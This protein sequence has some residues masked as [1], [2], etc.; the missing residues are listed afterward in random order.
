MVLPPQPAQSGSSSRRYERAVFYAQEIY[1]GAGRVL[2]VWQPSELL[3]PLALV[4]NSAIGEL[5]LV[6]GEQPLP[7][8]KLAR[9][10]P[11]A[12]A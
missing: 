10:Q 9:S 3:R 12:R 5:V 4:T 7:L 8:E 2:T 11:P 6:G 1:P